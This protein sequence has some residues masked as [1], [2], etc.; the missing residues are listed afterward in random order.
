MTDNIA[1]ITTVS[2]V[3]VKS[4]RGSVRRMSPNWDSEGCSSNSMM[5]QLTVIIYSEKDYNTRWNVLASS[6]VLGVTL[7]SKYVDCN[8]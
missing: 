1:E 7:I 8:A 2:I 3:H 5:L 6:L 4:H